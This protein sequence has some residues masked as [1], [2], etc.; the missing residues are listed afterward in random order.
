MCVRNY[1]NLVTGLKKKRCKF[2]VLMEDVNE[3]WLPLGNIHLVGEVTRCICLYSV[4]DF[5]S[6][7][8][9]KLYYNL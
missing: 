3:L 8:I 1:C 5:I 6:V 7:C 2:P 4:Q 9:Q